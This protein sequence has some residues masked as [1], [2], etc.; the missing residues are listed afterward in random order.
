MNGNNEAEEVSQA[1][2]LVEKSGSLPGFMGSGGWEYDRGQ[3]AVFTQNASS[4]FWLEM[5]NL[6]P[7]P[8]LGDSES[9]ESA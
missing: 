2:G 3:R 9:R 1:V 7:H 6:R 5:Q 4:V 8:R